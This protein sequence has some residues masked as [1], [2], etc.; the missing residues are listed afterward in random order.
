LN[1]V[2]FCLEILEPLMKYYFVKL[3]ESRRK[4]R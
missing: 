2:R 3:K 4:K 1:G